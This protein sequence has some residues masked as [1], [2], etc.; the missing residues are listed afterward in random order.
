MFMRALFA[1]V[2]PVDRVTGPP[3]PGDRD[4]YVK[5]KRY[6]KACYSLTEQRDKSVQ[7]DHNLFRGGTYRVLLLR[8]PPPRGRFGKGI[9]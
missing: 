6:Q 7:G 5:T 3:V 4:T 2:T 1:L 9:P 8:V